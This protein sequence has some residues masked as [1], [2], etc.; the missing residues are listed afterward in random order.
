MG[1]QISV[2]FNPDPAI[3]GHVH[4]F[5]EAENCRAAEVAFNAGLFVV[6]GTEDAQ[7]KLPTTSGEVAKGLGITPSAVASSDPNF[8]LG[9]TGETYQ[10]GDHVPA[11]SRGKVWVQ[12]EE[13]VVAGDIP[14]VRYATGAGGTQK[15]SFRKSADTATA[16]SLTGS[17]YLT[18]AAED[19]Y[20][21]VSVNL[22]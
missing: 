19:G 2:A 4:G 9:G 22:P 21:L 11:V 16:A 5:V 20:A 10:I 12:V 13:A 3:A 14:F 1:L 6:Q 15:G 7:C 18:S 8:P 17:L